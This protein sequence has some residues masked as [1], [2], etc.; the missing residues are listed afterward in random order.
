M[1]Q[2]SSPS[3]WTPLPQDSPAPCNRF[4]HACCSHKGDVYLLGGRENMTLRDFWKYS[5]VCNEWTELDCSSEWAPEE[6]EGHTMVSHQGILYAFG[7]LTDSAYNDWKIPLWL[8]D[9]EKEKWRY[10]QGQTGQPVPVNRKGH[11]TVVLGSAMYIYGGYIDMRGASQEFW[12]YDF[13]TGVWALLSGVQAEQGPGPRYGHAATAHPQGMYLY[14]GLSGLREQ[15]DLWRWS[16]ANHTWTYIKTYSGPPRL[17]GHSMVLYQNSLLLFGGCESHNC[18]LNDLWRLDLTAHRW[19]KVAAIKGSNPPGK[20]HHC[21]V[22]L[23]RGFQPSG[24]GLTDSPTGS[25]TISKFRPFKNKLSP[26]PHQ[27]LEGAIELQTLQPEKRGLRDDE[28]EDP[29]EDRE[30]RTC[31]VFENQDA[32]Q[33]T[34]DFEDVSD[35]SEE[36]IEQHL[37]EALLVIGGKPL[38]GQASLSVWQ[39]TL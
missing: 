13:D 27:W 24:T 17:V 37:P 8:F 29:K 3:L 1:A 12:K 11:T 26:S 18:P 14:G 9:T 32:F 28:E 31:L 22:G 36:S 4:R 33:K 21:A 5:V 6:L 2:R 7:G 34:W 38:V 35:C 10:S 19:E 15:R 20:F 39:M 16:Q 30:R 23:G 25:P